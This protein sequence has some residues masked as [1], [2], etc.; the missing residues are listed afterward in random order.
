MSN[1]ALKLSVIRICRSIFLCRHGYLGSQNGMNTRG[2][3]FIL[4]APKQ[5]ILAVSSSTADFCSILFMQHTEIGTSTWRDDLTRGDLC[6]KYGS[7]SI[8][9]SGR[10]PLGLDRR[11]DSKVTEDQ[12]RLL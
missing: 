2:S 6:R 3:S 9:S 7:E 11:S 4:H 1:N 8:T 10:E 12:I 5:K